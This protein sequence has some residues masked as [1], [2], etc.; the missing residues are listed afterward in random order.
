M[1][2]PTVLLCVLLGMLAAAADAAPRAG[3]FAWNYRNRPVV[4]PFDGYEY[5]VVS[6][7]GILTPGVAD[8]LKAFGASALVWLQPGVAVTNG[9]PVAGP[10]YAWDSAVLDLVNRRRALLRKPDGKPVDLRP[11]ASYGAQVLDYRDSAFVD[12]YAMRIAS[13]F[14]G[15]AA[16]VLLD[17]GCGDLGWA[18]LGVDPSL[19]PA[20]RRGFIRLCGRLQAHGLLV[21]VQ[22]DQYPDDLVAVTDG[23]FHEQ[24]GMSLNPLAKVW[25]NVIAHPDRRMFVR[26]EE[27]VPQKRRAFA[28]LSLL[29]GAR[30]N[31]SDVRGDYGGG[32]MENRRDFEHFGMSVGPPSGPIVT[33]APDVHSRTFERGVAVL[34][35]SSNPYVY[36]L[37]DTVQVTIRPNDGLVVQTKDA[38]GRAIR[39]ITNQG[40]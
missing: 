32:T 17:Y 38:S 36:R 13:E 11:G 15:R 10:D 1:P 23:A 26:V 28:T 19:W 21:V 8:S 7:R 40:R 2:A 27:L 25:A 30:F 33:L 18:D 20:W 16:G 22:C 34:N 4:A 39:R 12:E 6:P 5:V 14:R 29:T 3:T 24:A 31:W 37:T 9:I 35:A